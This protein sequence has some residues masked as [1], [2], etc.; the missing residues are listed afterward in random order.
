MP[1][2]SSNSKKKIWLRITLALAGLIL[3]LGIAI[4]IV[5]HIVLTPEKV[6]PIVLNL[7]NEYIDADVKCESIEITFFKTFPYLGVHLHNGN[8]INY[9]KHS[10]DSIAEYMNSP[11]DTLIGFNDCI[12]SFNPVAFLLDKKVIVNQIEVVH[13][14]IYAFVNPKG[15]TNWDIMSEKDSEQDTTQ[16]ILPEL[17]LKHLHITDANIIYDDREQNIFVA[18]DSLQLKIKGN[19]SNDSSSLDLHLDMKSLTTYSG[20]VALVKSL[21][22]GINAQLKNNKIIHR[23]AID[24]ALFSIGTLKLEAS[25]TLQRDSVHLPAQVDIDFQLQASSMADLLEMIPSNI[26]EINKKV[27]TTGSINSHG[28]IKGPLSKEEY[29]LLTM[30]FRLE[31]GSLRS[32]KHP[33]KSGIKKIDIDCDALIDMTYKTSSY[34][35]INNIILESASSAFECNGKFED[36]F[37]KPRIAAAIKGNI[38]FNRMSQD[39]PFAK[40]M[41]MGGLINM[42]LS[43][44]CFLDDVLALDYGKIFVNGEVDINNVLFN[45]P[46]ENINFFASSADLKLGSN[47]KDSIRGRE[48]ESLLKG[49]LEIDSINLNWKNEMTAN[50]SKLSTRFRTDNLTDTNK[51]A[52]MS[53]FIKFENLRFNMGDSIRIR[54][55]KTNGFF[56]TAPMENNP[57]YPEITARFTID[58]LRTRM[59]GIFGRVSN[60]KLTAKV[61]P[62]EVRSRRTTPRAVTDSAA[63]TRR[64]DSLLIQNQNTNLAFRLES[65][66]ARSILRKWDFSGSFE[67]NNMSLRTPYFPLPI[68]MI[69]SSLGFSSNSVSLKNTHLKAGSSDM[70]LTGEVEGIKQA[71]LRNG[72]ITARLNLTADSLDFNQLIRAAVTGA[73]YIDKDNVERDSIA[74]TVLDES[75]ELTVQ[76]DSI[77]TGVFVIPKNLDLEFNSNIK[78]AIYNQLHL[79]NTSGKII[80]RAQS[81]RLPDFYMDS[82]VGNAQI[83]LVYKAPNTK[84]A[85]LG[86]DLQMRQIYIKELIDAFP[87]IDTLTPMLKSF[88]GVVDCNMTAV[89]EL[90]SIMDIIMP[91]TTATCYLSGVNM[92]LLDG[93][94][95]TEISKMLMFKNK[96]RNMIDSIAVEMILENGKIMVFPFKVTIDRYS[97]GVGGT[98]NLDM[99]FNYHISVLKSPLPFK[100]GLNLSGN[101]DKMKIRLAKPKY[102][103]LFTPVKI[104]DLEASQTNV[105][106]QLHESLKRNIDEIM[107]APAAAPIRRPQVNLN[108]SLNNIFFKMDTTTV[109]YPLTPENEQSQATPDSSATATE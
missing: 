107:N 31:D 86:L 25:G 36:I 27:L 35:N 66:E 34:V 16:T 24:K 97:A 88:E 50:A 13:P 90:D 43:G 58:S 45:Y 62:L 56:R 5:I 10:E 94:T 2:D 40:D 17:N 3:L 73:E 42:N 67:C 47:V 78:N 12:V 80:I 54:A 72:K 81:I 11:Q 44:N 98:Q 33:E 99:S 96:K 26:T 51:I 57:K 60:A 22:L 7:A 41:K 68:R 93:E 105:R 65:N 14:V 30:A 77:E 70:I 37:T 32:A 106:Q 8:I 103:D 52:K 1:T 64:R 28:S 63:W 89:T 79:K 55:S 39:F 87:M 29:P 108:D 82:D 59:P 15:E 69:Q 20:D 83:S 76:T 104:Q 84:G 38:N 92:V 61:N 53:T 85:Y 49:N 75:K 100:I 109:N 4:G 18:V 102:K 6:T 101:P 91:K 46:E 74:Q 21:P 48:I 23:L 9:P 71:L 19:M 95:F